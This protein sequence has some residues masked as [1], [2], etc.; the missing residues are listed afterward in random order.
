VPEGDTIFRAARTLRT[1][2]AGK[3]VTRFETVLPFLARVHYDTPLTG[4]TIEDVQSHG[5]WI[6]MRF[7]GDLILLTHMLMSGSWHIYRPGERWKRRRDD[8]RIVICTEGMEAVAFK[9]PVAEF[10]TAASLARRPGF[11]QL[12]QDVLGADFDETAAAQQ[13]RSSADLEIGEALLSQSLLAGIGNVYKSEVCF[14]CGIHPYRLSG[15]L[16]EDD[17]HRLVA[18]ARKFLAANVSDT[19]SEQIVT[20]T[21]FRRT[22]GRANP[23]DRLW[24]Y[25]RAGEPCRKCGT[26]IR[27]SRQGL[28]A[29]VTFWCPNCQR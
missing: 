3:Q 16:T 10:H 13:L 22:T 8:M 21:G 29:R 28:G 25:G 19:S 18:T 17:A 2:L 7:S 11:S 20:Y 23:G 5:K 27:K 12:G 6:E 1:A 24:V 4:R 26:P 15:S 14:T 9:V